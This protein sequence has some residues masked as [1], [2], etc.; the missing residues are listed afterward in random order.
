MADNYWFETDV[1]IVAGDN[2]ALTLTFASSGSAVDVSSWEFYYKAAA[3]WTDDTVSIQGTKSDS[4]TGT[5][6]SVTVSFAGSDT[7]ID[8]GKYQHS[9]IGEISG[10]IRTVFRGSLTIKDKRAVVV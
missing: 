4:G 3:S 6:D 2:D 7:D 9:L 8:V 1:E 10:D 5:T